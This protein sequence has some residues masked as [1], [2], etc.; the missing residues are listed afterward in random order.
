MLLGGMG[1][2]N[3]EEQFDIAHYYPLF[4]RTCLQH[5]HYANMSMQYIAIF[6]VCKND[7]FSDE[8]M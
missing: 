5:K 7:N 2:N 3:I 1:D 6:H 4:T 8:K